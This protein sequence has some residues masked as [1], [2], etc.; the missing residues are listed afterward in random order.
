LF[1]PLLSLAGQVR[2]PLHSAWIPPRWLTGTHQPD[3][4]NTRKTSGSPEFPSYPCEY[5]P[6]SKTPV[7]SLMLA[8]T[9]AGLLPSVRSTTS[10]FSHTSG[11]IPMTTTIHFSGLNTKPAS[12]FHPASDSPLGVC[13]RTSL[14]TWWLTFSQVG[15]ESLLILTHWVTI[16]NFIPPNGN[17]ND[18]SLSRHDERLVIANVVSG[19]TVHTYSLLV[20]DP[21]RSRNKT[22]HSPCQATCYD[23]AVEY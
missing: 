20:V 9:Y 18:L 10:A 16:S 6:W 17:P 8:I 2:A 15:L 11:I 12:L 4:C 19:N 14:L 3:Y 7:V 22:E 21:N 5:M 1:A 23:L 13:P